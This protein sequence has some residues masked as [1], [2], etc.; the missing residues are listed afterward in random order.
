MRRVEEDRPWSLFCPSDVGP[1]LT[2]FGDSFDDLYESFEQY[3][4]AKKVLPARAI[5]EVILESQAETGGPFMLYKDSI[6][7]EWRDL[8]HLRILFV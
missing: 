3:G 1:L 4:I 6:N 7:S 5:W 2:A 8:P